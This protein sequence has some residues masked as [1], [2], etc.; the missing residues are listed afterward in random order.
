MS[1][2]AARD[3]YQNANG[4]HLPG[5]HPGFRIPLHSDT[6]TLP[7]QAMRAAMAAA[8]V[9]DEQRRE[10]P[11][12]NALQDEMA[13]ILGHEAALFLPSATMANQIAVRLHGRQGEEA[14]VHETAHI[15]NW[16]AGAMAALS[17]VTP[18]SLGGERGIM[19]P[20]TIDRAIR[21]TNLHNPRTAMICI[22]NTTNVAGGFVW[23][24]EDIDPV[25][26]L[27]RKHALP[28]HCDGS[29]L[30]NAAIAV[31]SGRLDGR[32]SRVAS[33]DAGVSCGCGH[34]PADSF[35]SNGTGPV[36]K[37]DNPSNFAIRQAANQLSRS[38]DT[39]TICF[40]KGFGAPVGAV[41]A[42]SKALMERAMRLKHQ[43]GGAMRQ[44]GILAAAC[45]HALN[46]HFPLM[47]EDH[48]RA[49]KMAEGLNKIEGFAIPPD[50]VESNILIVTVVDPAVSCPAV[51]AAFQAR[52]VGCYPFGR[53]FRLVTHLGITDA[54]VDEVVSMAPEVLRN[55]AATAFS[56]GTSI[57]VGY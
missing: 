9:G 7:T 31:A 38:L 39:V 12:V 50:Q 42:G 19:T 33:L 34:K 18:L 45:T 51:A 28:V 52:G 48:R 41:L 10:D 43:F 56:R 2:A 47:C 6:A 11:S 37:N 3:L 36:R 14:I 54:M 35:D 5:D 32:P 22:E 13:S 25:V 29:R 44:A 21:G 27:A 23:R 30:F 46:H 26:T 20:E 24:P 1:S 53:C 55:A 16:E 57:R 8:T 15:S 40:S 17:G 4:S 49:R